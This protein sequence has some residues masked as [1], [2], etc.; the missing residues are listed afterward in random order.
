[1]LWP[2][3]LISAYPDYGE[4]WPSMGNARLV[5]AQ[6]FNPLAGMLLTG[7]GVWPLLARHEESQRDDAWRFVL[8]PAL[9]AAGAFTFFRTD[10]HFR[11]FMWTFAIG[12]TLALSR[13]RWTGIVA[14]AGWTPV[15]AVVA[16]SLV[17]PADATRPEIL[18]PNGWLLSVTPSE[19]AR[20]A[21]IHGALVAL[22]AREGSG[23][24]LFDSNGVGFHVAY[25]IPHISRQTWF[26]QAAVRPYELDT[27]ARQYRRLTAL[28]VCRDR[29]A[30]PAADR[31]TR[32]Q[33]FPARLRGELDT[34]V[35]ETLWSDGTCR[36]LRL[37]A[38]SER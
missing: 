20:I 6:Y 32:N 26:Y 28:V 17:R 13:Y 5:V 1:V 7:L 3:Y 10:H 8:L 25:G 2:A 18:S 11:Q 23:P 31:G 27:L 21:G 19:N 38:A 22:A 34:R 35:A 9:F 14:I 12:S 16:L 15:A 33:R 30:N 37:R 29:G 24:V 36:L 4:R